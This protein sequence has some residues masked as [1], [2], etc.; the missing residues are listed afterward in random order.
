M[1][2]KKQVKKTIAKPV[3][4]KPDFHI[5]DRILFVS[6]MLL[7]FSASATLA[8]TKTTAPV[9][10]AP[11]KAPVVQSKPAEPQNVY[12]SNK[13]LLGGKINGDSTD[14]SNQLS[15]VVGSATTYQ[16]INEVLDSGC[17]LRI[18]K[19]GGLGG[20]SGREAF[21]CGYAYTEDGDN[22]LYCDSYGVKNG[23][24]VTYS[25]IGFR[26]DGNKVFYISDASVGSVDVKLYQY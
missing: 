3:V 14:P 19:N 26:F 9:K 11:V 7:V 17:P 2:Q 20:G 12:C 13:L 6:L 18:V 22:V 8:A 1:R 25:K 4:S 16:K 21:D 23:K 5:T 10:A 15:A 24:D